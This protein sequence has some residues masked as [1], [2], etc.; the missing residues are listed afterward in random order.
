MQIWNVFEA[1]EV[2][3]P[4]STLIRCVVFSPDG[5]EIVTLCD[6]RIDVSERTVG[7]KYSGNLRQL[8]LSPVVEDWWKPYKNSILKRCVSWHWNISRHSCFD[9]NWWKWL[10]EHYHTFWYVA[11][12]QTLLH[13]ELNIYELVFTCKCNNN[14]FV[15][16]WKLSIIYGNYLYL[17]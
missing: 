5:K 12:A 11:N 10:S 17:H 1:R 15:V 9:Y 13:T 14:Y 16:G 3:K 4:S 2:N 6:D 8:S 7:C